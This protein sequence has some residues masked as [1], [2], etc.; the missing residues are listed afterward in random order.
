MAL[1]TEDDVVAAL[2]RS[3]TSTESG[4][5]ENLLDEASDLVV[6]YLGFSPDP[7]PGAVARVVASMVVAVLLK[8]SVSVADYDASGYSTAREAASVRVGVESATTTGP[9]LT[10]A[11]RERLRPFRIA[12][13]SVRMISDQY[14]GS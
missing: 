6:G 9:W 7:V 14:S 5:V 10:N 11:L 1:A 8:P 12:V 4:V 2:G 13:V 3:L